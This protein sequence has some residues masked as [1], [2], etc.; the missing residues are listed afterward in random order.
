MDFPQDD[1]F[2]RACQCLERIS[3][4]KEK[5]LLEDVEYQELRNL[6][7][8]EMR[9]SVTLT[10][11]KRKEQPL[12]SETPQSHS[13]PYSQLHA[14]IV[15]RISIS[16]KSPGA[17]P[18]QRMFRAMSEMAAKQAL[19]PGDSADLEQVIETVFTPL[20]G[21]LEDNSG[22]GARKLLQMLKALNDISTKIRNA[23]D[24]S[25][26]AKAIAETTQQSANQAAEEFDT[27]RR[28]PE[29]RTTT[30]KNWWGKL[31]LKDVEGA[32]EGGSAAVTIFPAFSAAFPW[33]LPIAAAFGVVLGA[34]IRS[35][36][37]YGEGNT[38]N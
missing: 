2:G 9:R 22:E 36:I 15:K 33:T 6:L 7:L 5:K 13:L 10:E 21:F 17:D 37:A 18:K 19:Y 25:P 12:H 11:E 32:F 1:S 26:A 20:D 14:E 29:A 8:S 28:Q 24:T 30:L 23:P 16:Y 3:E 34:G 27:Q 38:P 35:G 31:V 4:L